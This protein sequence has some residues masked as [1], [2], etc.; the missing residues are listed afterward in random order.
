MP[1]RFHSVS[2]FTILVMPKALLDDAHSDVFVMSYAESERNVG[3]MVMKGSSI[4][5]ATRRYR[6]GGSERIH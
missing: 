6:H 5:S 1:E 2:P 4:G 3:C